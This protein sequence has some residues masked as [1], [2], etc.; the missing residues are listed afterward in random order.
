[1]EQVSLDGAVRHG[2][3]VPVPVE[4]D[5]L[6]L[7]FD[8]G[9]KVQ[10]HRGVLVGDLEA[11]GSAGSFPERSGSRTNHLGLSSSRSCRMRGRDVRLFEQSGR[12]VRVQTLALLEQRLVRPV[13]CE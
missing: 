1:M 2:L 13:A 11:R 3:F 9:D 12:L 6:A 10:W 4:L 7:V 8:K 5:E